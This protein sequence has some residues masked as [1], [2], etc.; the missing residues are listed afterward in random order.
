MRE[1]NPAD[2]L[3]HHQ[4]QGGPQKLFHFSRKV[5]QEEEIFTLDSSLAVT[6]PIML[7]D[8]PQ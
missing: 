3:W 4:E 7:S 2:A 5:S 8:L 1:T 6:L